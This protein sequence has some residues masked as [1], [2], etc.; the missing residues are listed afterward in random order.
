LP[1]PKAFCVVFAK[2]KSTGRS[3]FE[4]ITI[5][6]PHHFNHVGKRRPVYKPHTTLYTPVPGCRVE[7]A[8][9]AELAT[10]KTQLEREDYANEQR[11]RKLAEHLTTPFPPIA[12]CISSPGPLVLNIKPLPATLHFHTKSQVHQ[13]RDYKRK[14]N[15]TSMCL[16]PFFERLDKVQSSIDPKIA[17]QLWTFGGR[18]NK[19]YANLTAIIEEKGLSTREWKEISQDLS[20]VGKHSFQALKP[21][22]VKHCQELVSK[23]GPNWL[24][25]AEEIE[26]VSV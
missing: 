9:Q 3:L 25:I 18:F 10:F 8:R 24:K 11:K 15:A 23:L 26:L 6:D 4:R 12:S 20:K 19:L 21:C 13:L 17:D 16:T 5:S 22:F 2:D 14:F 1:V 7:L